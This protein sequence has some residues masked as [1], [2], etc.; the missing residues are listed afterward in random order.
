MPQDGLA[1]QRIL[2][3]VTLTLLIATV[4]VVILWW[5]S[6]PDTPD[7]FYKGGVA[8]A[9]GTLVRSEALSRAVPAGERAWRILYVTTRGDGRRTLASGVVMAPV[10]SSGPRPV[11]AW[12]HGATGV[13]RGCAPSMLPNPF[14]D[15]AALREVVAKGWVLVAIDYAGLGT[16]GPHAFLSG[17]DEARSELDAIR[18]ARQ[19][20]SVSLE[21]NVVAWGHSQGGHAALWTGI[22]GPRYAPD[23]HLAGIAAIAP[24]TDLVALVA[25][26]RGPLINVLF[27]YIVHAYS[28]IYPDVKEAD[29][30]SRRASLFEP[31]MASRCLVDWR[32]LVAFGEAQLAGETIFSSD[33]TKGP[34]GEHLAQNTP[35]APMPEPVLIAQG[36]ADNVILPDIQQHFVQQRC[37]AGQ[38]LE[39]Q[40]YS[41]QD[42]DSIVSDR[43]P[44][45]G[46]L[47][48]WTQDRFAGRPQ[49]SGCHFS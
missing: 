41:G 43:S 47:V 40:I 4:A 9:P 8:G 42:H 25:R 19:L 29:Y 27:S 33:P 3:W 48:R 13:D 15:V 49:A 18:A 16:E 44:L 35:A 11:V 39:Y 32:A 38:S 12:A 31:D 30:V 17:E 46:K 1:T 20:K 36:G 37:A 24:A 2:G 28:D 14:S 45:S 21:N 34:L 22:V 7:A 10:H 6:R 5:V 23:V 26:D